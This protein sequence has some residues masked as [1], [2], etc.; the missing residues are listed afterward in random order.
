MRITNN[1]LVNNLKNNLSR[2]IF[3]MEKIQ[4]QL[5][6]GKRISRPS[7]DPTGIVESMH[8]ASRLRENKAFQDNA[9]EAKSW[10]STTDEALDGL[11]VALRRAYELTVQAANGV[12][13]PEDQAAVKAEIEQI[14]EEV[15]VIAN[16]IHNDRYIFGGTNTKNMP[17][18]NGTWQHNQQ[19]IMYEVSIGVTIPINLTAEEVFVQADLIGTLQN[20]ATHLET[21]DAESLGSTDISA[22]QQ[23]I[24]QVLACRA[25]VGASIN[26]LEMTIARLEEQEV[27]YSNLQAEIDG[28]DPAKLIM[29][30]KNAENVYQASLSVG[31]RIIMPTL[32]DYL[33]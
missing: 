20:V 17:Y 6:T 18:N 19:S 22:L 28:V 7:Q 8:L 32:V 26:R 33:R 23:G 16:T 30:L 9:Q 25:K 10:L 4:N 24:D 11:T 13:A 3:N 5:A 14:V 1:V 21:G 29:E 27:N 31:A 15:G 12:L 2:N